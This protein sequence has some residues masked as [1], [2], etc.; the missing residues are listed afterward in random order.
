M[1]KQLIQALIFLAI[2]QAGAQAYFNGTVKEALK[3]AS[4]NNVKIMV[5]RLPMGM[6]PN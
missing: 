3:G 5:V 1:R 4:L 2:R 6:L